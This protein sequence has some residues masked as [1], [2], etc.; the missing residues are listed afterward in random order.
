MQGTVSVM[1]LCNWVFMHSQV[2]LI[3]ILKNCACCSC[4]VVLSNVDVK[5]LRVSCGETKTPDAWSS[6]Q[7]LLQCKQRSFRYSLFFPHYLCMMYLLLCSKETLCH[8]YSCYDGCLDFGLVQ[9]CV[10]T[11][12]CCAPGSE[13]P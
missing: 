3:C 13:L 10:L 7:I 6:E 5:G 12:V 1:T 8:E 2:H 11:P 4:C 9:T